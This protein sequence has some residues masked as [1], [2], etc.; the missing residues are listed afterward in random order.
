ML[1]ACTESFAGCSAC[2]VR[3]ASYA[4]SRVDD[5]LHRLGCTEASS[6]EAIRDAY[7]KRAKACHRDR[8]LGRR[9]RA[10]A[11]ADA[12][13]RRGD[14]D[15]RGY[16][17][18]HGFAADDPLAVHSVGRR[19]RRAP[20]NSLRPRNCSG[21]LDKGGMWWLAEQMAGEGTRRR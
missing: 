3:H 18:G 20:G 4:R 17:A 12:R 21:G 11:T 5:A 1:S 14:D 15:A 8:G 16:D 10:L 2:T 13:A 19:Q 9:V 7:Y 6:R